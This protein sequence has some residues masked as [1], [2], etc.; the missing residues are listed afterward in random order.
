MHHLSKPRNGENMKK[1]WIIIGMLAAVILAASFA[2]A[3]WS[4]GYAKTV[5]TVPTV[6]TIPGAFTVAPVRL[7]VNGPDA[8]ITIKGKNFLKIGT[9]F[10]SQ[11]R[12]VGPDL[13]TLLL[14]TTSISD[15]GMTLT[16]TL[17]ANY[18]TKIGDA[19]L[20]VVNHPTAK[21]AYE[22][23]GPLSLQVT[24]IYYLPLSVR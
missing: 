15:D 24:N 21:D 10:F 1:S 16:A 6:P 14:E 17:P 19:Y 23:A 22:L 12:W 7:Q 9:E 13:K 3:N 8:V 11:V 5:P 20:W 2:S 4:T 18:I